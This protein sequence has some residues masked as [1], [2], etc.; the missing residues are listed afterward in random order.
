MVW[1]IQFPEKSLY[2]IEIILC[3][4]LIA[5]IVLSWLVVLLL[6]TKG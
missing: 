5:E 2:V 1:A 3:S 6:K 4:D